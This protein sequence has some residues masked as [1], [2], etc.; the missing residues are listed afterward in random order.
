LTA[1]AFNRMTTAFAVVK[2]HYTGIMAFGGAVLIVMGV[3]VFSGELFRLNVQ[4]QEFLNGL[5]IDFF[6][7]V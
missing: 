5:G 6:N 1:L 2:R 4:A 3:L 7:E